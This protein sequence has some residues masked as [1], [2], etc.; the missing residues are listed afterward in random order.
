MIETKHLTKKF[1]DF[2]AVDDLNLSIEKGELFSL[3]GLNGAGKTTTIKMLSCLILPSSGNAIIFNKDL[4]KD[5]QYIKQRINVSPQE[6]AIARNLNIQENLEMIAGIYGIS[7][8]LI[9][10]KV[11]EMIT[12][13]N[14]SEVRKKKARLLSGGMQRRLSI[15]MALITD[16]EILFLDE[17]TLGLDVIARRELW[18]NIK[19]LK[20]K[21]TIILTT[22]YLEEAEA[23]SDRVAIIQKGRIKAIGTVEEILNQTNTKKLEDAFVLLNE[24]EQTI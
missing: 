16:P 14:L 1:G 23:L 11:E 17:P 13:F 9:S 6:T 4:I 20:E 8:N 18:S 12:V 10:D 22:H 7:K 3:L 15:A 21:T 5:S 19:K 2:V 24:E